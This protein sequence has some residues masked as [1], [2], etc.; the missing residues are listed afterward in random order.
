MESNLFEK[1]KVIAS[2][3]CSYFAH[4]SDFFKKKRFLRK[5]SKTGHENLVLITSTVQVELSKLNFNFDDL[6]TYFLQV[7][8][9]CRLICPLSNKN[10]TPLFLTDNIKMDRTL[11]KFF[12][13]CFKF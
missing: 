4:I 11:T 1:F 10:P 2:Y 8:R 6:R 7:L 12:A 3:Q 9:H 5:S 13:L